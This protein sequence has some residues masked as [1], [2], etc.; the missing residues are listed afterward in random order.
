MRILSPFDGIFVS[1]VFLLAS[2]VESGIRLILVA[3]QIGMEVAARRWRVL[4]V[5]VRKDPRATGDA[6]ITKVLRYK[7][8]ISST[9]I[10]VAPLG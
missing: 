5:R 1:G 4:P 2:I 9:V 3:V 10:R 8:L 7:V 6:P